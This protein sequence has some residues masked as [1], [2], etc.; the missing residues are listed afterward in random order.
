M[1]TVTLRCYHADDGS[2][3]IDAWYRAQDETVQGAVDGALDVLSSIARGRWGP[4]YFKE[5]QPRPGARCNG[6]AE[7]TLEVSGVHYRIF[8]YDGPRPTD[9][10]L[11]LP[12]RK[13][14]DPRYR[15]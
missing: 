7:V 2:D 8:G 10:T 14:D 1:S 15:A 5:L 12:I 9:F 4:P 13:N 6:L 11:L 3:A